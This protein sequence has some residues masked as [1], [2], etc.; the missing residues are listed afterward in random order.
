MRLLLA[1]NSKRLKFLDQKGAEAHKVEATQLL[2]RKL[3]TRIRIAV[4]VIAKVSKKIDRVRDEELCP[5]I[6]ALI[7]G[8]ALFFHSDL[9]CQ[10]F[11]FITLLVHCLFLYTGCL[12]A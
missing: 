2:V 1:K 3:S 6:K 4:R 5:Q 10:I 8:Y 7:Q 9:C 12:F 11:Q